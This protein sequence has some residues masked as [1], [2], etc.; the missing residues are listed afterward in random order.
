MEA[1]VPPDVRVIRDAAGA[2][3]L[4]DYL[5]VVRVVGEPRRRPG[6]RERGEDHLPARGEAGR[7][8]AP[9]RR[10]GRER[11]QRPEL[12]E[13]PVHDLDRLL[14]IVDGDVDVHP[15][16]QLPPGDVL[17][18]VDEI[19]VAV[20]RRD[21]LPLEERERMRSGGADPHSLLAPDL[22]DVGPELHELGLDVAGGAADRCR[23]LEH[24]LHQLGVDPRLQLVP[25]DRLQDGVDV[26]DEIERLAVE[27]HVLL[28]DAQRVRIRLAE[29]VVEHAAA[30]DGALARDR[31]RIDLLHG[32]SASAS[33]STFQRG[34]SRPRITSIA[35]AGRISEKTS[36]CARPT[37]CQSSACVR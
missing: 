14:G 34:S 35:L 15:E 3:E 11:E 7:L 23:D 9:E 10:A 30:V 32:S 2:L 5:G 12:G 18:L 37:S 21:P 29:G 16:D 25:A 20:A 26:L 4:A 28:L 31:R 8:A 1:D 27:E 19:A 17:E 6:A 33:I 22:H 36:P 24:R 13:E